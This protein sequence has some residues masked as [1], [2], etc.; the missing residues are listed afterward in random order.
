MPAYAMSPSSTTNTVESQ[1]PLTPSTTTTI[2]PMSAYLAT[3]Y[4]MAEL[5]T[6]HCERVRKMPISGL[7]PS[8][9]LGFLCKNEADWKDFRER[10]ADVR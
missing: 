5:R 10:I 2:D 4:S 7:D 8:M 3:S 9:L 6:F 1:I